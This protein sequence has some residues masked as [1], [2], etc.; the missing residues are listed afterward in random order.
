MFLGSK[1]IQIYRESCITN[2]DFNTHGNKCMSVSIVGIY[3]DGVLD[4][5]ITLLDTSHF[6]WVVKKCLFLWSMCKFC[7]LTSIEMQTYGGTHIRTLIH[8]EINLCLFKQYNILFY[9][10][11]VS[12]VTWKQ[13]TT[14]LWADFV[15]KI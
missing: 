10:I 1:K 14:N 3:H 4:P 9:I 8:M 12:F 13:E 7:Y 15:L 11:C 2:L 6:I 5:A